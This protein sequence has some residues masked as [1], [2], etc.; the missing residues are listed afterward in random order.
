LTGTLARRIMP[1]TLNRWSA[2]TG[3][4]SPPSDQLSEPG[5]CEPAWVVAGEWT[6][7]PRPERRRTDGCVGGD[8]RPP[9]PRAG[10]SAAPAS[11]FVRAERGPHADPQ[12][13]WH[14]GSTPP[15]FGIGGVA[16]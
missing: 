5:W 13:G 7:E 9:L 12:R 1:G 2:S 6:R 16:V 11:R 4:S 3:T 8:G 10:A 14:H 15:S